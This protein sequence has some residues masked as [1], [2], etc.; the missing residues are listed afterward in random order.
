[1]P[2]GELLLVVLCLT[3]DL[4]KLN[5]AITTEFSTIFTYASSKK[6]RRSDRSARSAGS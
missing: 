2:D 4:L 3:A 6:S 5:F 1:M